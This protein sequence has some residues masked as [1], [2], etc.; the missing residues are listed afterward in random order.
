M[1]PSVAM[2]MKTRQIQLH[3]W[4]YLPCGCSRERTSSG[5]ASTIGAAEG[6]N[7]QVVD[8]N[9]PAVQS[10]A[11]DP[12][13]RDEDEDEDVLKPLEDSGRADVSFVNRI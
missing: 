7:S 9:V 8:P 5:E 13:N 12:A 3:E 2:T 4:C 10:R 11:S 1:R 6:A